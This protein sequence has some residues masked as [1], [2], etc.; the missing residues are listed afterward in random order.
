MKLN[1][2]AVV[3]YNWT[4]ASVIVDLLKE[5]DDYEEF[6]SEFCLIWDKDGLLDLELSL[7]KNWEVLNQDVAVRDFLEYIKMVQKRGGK[8]TKWAVDINNI[9]DLSLFKESENY[10]EKLTKFR[11]KSNRFLLD[12][13]LSFFHQLLNRLKRKKEKILGRVDLSYVDAYFVRPTEKEFLFATRNYIDS[14]FYKFAKRKNIS[15]IILDQALPAS[16]LQQTMRYFNNI[17]TVVVDRDPRDVYLNLIK[18]KILIGLECSLEKDSV[19]KFI[20]WYKTIRENRKENEENILRLN[21]EDIVLDYEYNLKIIQDFLDIKTN[22]TK[23]NK[24]FNPERSKKNIGLWKTYKNQDE[25]KLI[26]SKLK[27]YC[28]QGV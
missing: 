15:N 16:N 25:M 23:K 22:H 6:G 27:Q 5:F 3:G 21:F 28:N 26:Y 8:S 9:L 11:Y 19:N 2:I 18:R 24:Y 1:Y 4:G 13:K 14:L 7:F 12:Y 20:S 10:I 17:K